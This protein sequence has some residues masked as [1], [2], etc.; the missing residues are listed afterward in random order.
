MNGKRALIALAAAA[1]A[2]AIAFCGSTVSTG[3]S[4]ESSHH[5]IEVQGATM[6]PVVL[7]NGDI[8]AQDL[9]P[10]A[11]PDV[12]SPS[13]SVAN[14]NSFSTTVTITFKEFVFVHNGQYGH[15]PSPGDLLFGVDTIGPVNAEHLQDRSFDLGTL[16]PHTVRAFHVTIA[17]TSA[18]GNEW[19]GAVGYLPY[20]V[21]LTQR[22]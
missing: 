18:A 5:T 12:I 6:A 1:G 2:G 13:P 7:L 8:S 20:T 15:T 19:Q 22:S 3:F 10:G 11:P 14:N 17:L 9:L 4:T 16:N 21:T